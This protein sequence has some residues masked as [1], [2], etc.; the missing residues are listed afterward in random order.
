MYQVGDYVVYKRD[1]C[2]VK[3]I[4]QKYYNNLDYYILVSVLDPT[5]KIDVPVDNKSG[6]LRDLISKEDAN[7]L[8][9]RIPAIETIDSDDKML[10]NVYKSLLQSGSYEDLIKII[11]TTYLRNKNR[12]DQNKKIS[13]KDDNYFR[14]SEKY[15]YTEL[16]VVFGLTYEET[17]NYIIDKVKKWIINL[18]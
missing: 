16:S 9:N 10:E 7:Q 8:I 3:E 15:L 12:S 5:L 17:K 1:V 18:T 4:K 11:K 6:F 13:E 2:C 14:L